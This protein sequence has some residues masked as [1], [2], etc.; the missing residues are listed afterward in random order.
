[1]TGMR[2]TTRREGT[3]M[4]IGTSIFRMDGNPLFS[5][6][7]GAGGK[8]GTFVVE[9][10]QV[11]HAPAFVITI[12]HRSP[13]ETTWSDAGTFT[14]ITVTGTQPKTLGGLKELLRFKYSFTSTDPEDGVHFVMLAPTWSP[15]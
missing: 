9:V 12:Q 13:D 7:F 10:Q 5:P 11:V 15:S 2:G 14:T 4:V 6:A 8:G 3:A 1:F